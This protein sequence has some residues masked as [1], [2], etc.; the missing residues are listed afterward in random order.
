MRRKMGLKLVWN[1]YRPPARGAEVVS[2]KHAAC[3]TR[4]GSRL[5][6]LVYALGYVLKQEFTENFTFESIEMEHAVKRARRAVT[7]YRTL[8]FRKTVCYN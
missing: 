8:T 7:G 1:K 6:G 4:N 2:P 3:T 5:V